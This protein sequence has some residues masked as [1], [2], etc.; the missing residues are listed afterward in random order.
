MPLGEPRVISK[1]GPP[2][3]QE[4]QNLSAPLLGKLPYQPDCSC[5]WNSIRPHLS[6]SANPFRIRTMFGCNAKEPGERGNLSNVGLK[7][8]GPLRTALAANKHMKSSS[9]ALTVRKMHIET[10]V[11]YHLPPLGVTKKAENPK[12]CQGGGEIGTL[13][14]CG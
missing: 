12:C 13:V 11:G 4:L 14:H 2:P 6:L 8:F 1:G 5:L 3:R 10:S 7:V 9:T